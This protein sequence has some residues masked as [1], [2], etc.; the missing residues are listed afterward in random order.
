M[1]D[2]NGLRPSRYYITDSGYMILA[3]EV[4]AIA[5]DQTHVIKKDR[6]RPGKMLL[7][8]TKAGRL[9][10]DEE[11]KSRY[12]SRQPFGEWLDLNLIDLEDLHVPNEGLPAMTKE[13]SFVWSAPTAIPTSSTGP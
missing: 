6:L 11:L 1:L 4:G 2:R 7:V 3:S 10:S 5:I 9:V 13:E 8:D 12:A